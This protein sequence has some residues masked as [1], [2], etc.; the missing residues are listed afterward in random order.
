MTHASSP[1]RELI[2]RAIIVQDGALLVNRS[3]SA[4]TNQEYFALPGGHVDDGESCVA[5][6]L[7]E[8]REELDVEIEIQDMCFVSESIYSGRKKND[9]PRHELTLYF[10]ADLS[11]PLQSNGVEIVSPEKS[12]NFQWLRFEELS[13]ANLLPEAIKEFLLSTL[14]EEETPHYVF[15]DS[16]KSAAPQPDLA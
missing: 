6:L 1:A 5:A 3:H 4:K 14:D 13:G 10:H 11:T 16:T 12:K 2:A 15:E 7:R 9:G 8:C